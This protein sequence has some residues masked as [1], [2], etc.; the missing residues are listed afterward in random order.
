MVVVEVAPPP[1]APPRGVRRAAEV[2]V[3]TEAVIMTEGGLHRMI[4]TSL[5]APLPPVMEVLVVS[6]D[7]IAMAEVGEEEEEELLEV[8]VTLTALAEAVEV[9]TVQGHLL[10]VDHLAPPWEAAATGEVHRQHLPRPADTA[11]GQVGVA[12]PS[13]A[14]GTVAALRPREAMGRTPTPTTAQEVVP[15]RGLRG[16]QVVAPLPQGALS[17]EVVGLHHAQ[18]PQRHLGLATLVRPRGATGGVVVRLEG[19]AVVGDTEEGQTQLGVRV[20]EGEELEVGPGMEVPAVSAHPLV[21]LE[22]TVVQHL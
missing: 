20:T 12:L 3:V 2:L 18:V 10:P 7:E 22:V 21:G 11:Q 17:V 1:E 16:V 14:W 19:A 15:P 9:A 6:L 5:L 8:G 13:P 4:A